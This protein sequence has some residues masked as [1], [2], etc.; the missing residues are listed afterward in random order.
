MKMQLY[1]SL[2]YFDYCG[3]V[4]DGLSNELND[5]LQRL[6]NC[7]IGVITNYNSARASP[8]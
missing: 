6:L 2:P 3:P 1:C 8:I 4:S 7:A 5:K